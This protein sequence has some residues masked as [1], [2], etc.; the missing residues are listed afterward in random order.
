MSGK[1][2]NDVERAKR[3]VKILQVKGQIDVYDVMMQYE[4]SY[5]RAIPIFRLAARICENSGICE[6]DEKEHKL[7]YVGAK[8]STPSIKDVSQNLKKQNEEANERQETD[9]GAEEAEKI[10]NAKPEG[11]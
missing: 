2:L 8:P 1:R 3:L 5:T 4:I 7:I 11:E 6:Y 9:E 10:L